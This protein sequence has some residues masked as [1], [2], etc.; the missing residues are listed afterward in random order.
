MS[1]QNDPTEPIRPLDDTAATAAF[2][3]LP[4]PESAADRDESSTVPIGSFDGTTQPIGTPAPHAS[5]TPTA[6][7]GAVPPNG[8]TTAP[9]A[10][11]PAY[12]AFAQTTIARPRVRGAGIVW[13]LLFAAFGVITALLLSDPQSRAN[14]GAWTA[15]LNPGGFAVVA[16]LA[17]GAFILVMGI[18]ALV[19]RAQRR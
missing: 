8:F 10:P 15:S 13:G 1:N 18:I 19:R 17:L 6:A 11:T 7:Y 4:L 3:T 16:A 2:E 5:E 14:F 12:G 9:A